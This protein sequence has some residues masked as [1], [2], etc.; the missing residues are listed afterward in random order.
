[1]CDAPQRANSQSVA[2]RD[3]TRFVNDVLEHPSI[4]AATGWIVGSLVAFVI[5]LTYKYAPGAAARAT[6]VEGTAPEGVIPVAAGYWAIA[7][8]AVLAILA[9]LEP[10]IGPPLA[11]WADDIRQR[12]VLRVP[13]IARLSRRD[14]GL[15]R[16]LRWRLWWAVPVVLNFL[17]AVLGLVLMVIWR[18]PSFVLSLFDWLL[19][20]PF[21]I[22]AG[23]TLRPW[24]LR[25]G[26]LF[27]VLL[28][29]AWLGWSLP[30]PQGLYGIAAGILAIFAVV[31]RW[32]WIER[33]REAFMTARG[34]D[35]EIERIGFAEDLRD[36]ALI[37]IVF[38]FLLIPLGLRQVDLAYDAFDLAR[39]E[40]MPAEELGQ[41]LK[42]L[43][44]FGA[45]LAKAVPLVD[46]S[47]VFHVANG[48]PITARTALGAQIVF[49][50]RASLDLLLI[51]AVVQAVQIAGRLNAQYS[52]FRVGKLPILDP[53]AERREFRKL[54]GQLSKHPHVPLI[55][56]PA[57][58]DFPEY[59][60]S[61]LVTVVCGDGQRQQIRAQIMRDTEARGACTVILAK[62]GWDHPE[63]L[64]DKEITAVLGY[65]VTNP[66]DD[67]V[68]RTAMRLLVENDP[69]GA[70]WPLADLVGDDAAPA[71]LRE[72]AARELGWL[73][74][75]SAG[76]VLLGCLSSAKT[77]REVRAQAGLALAKLG[78]EDAQR[79]DED[80]Q[81]HLESLAGS[82]SGYLSD[83][84]LI[85]VMSTAYA[86]ARSGG[87]VDKERL[88]A[89]FAEPLRPHALRAIR[90]ATEEL[91]KMK[92]VDADSFNMGENDLS[93]WE[94]PQHLVAVPAFELGIYTVT[95]EEYDAFCVATRPTEP[96]IT[97]PKEWEEWEKERPKW[98]VILVTWYDAHEYCDWLNSFTGEHFRL[99]SE[100][101]W[102]FACRAGSPTRYSWGDDFGFN[103]ANSYKS[104]LGRPSRVGSYDAN[105]WGFFDMHGNV[106][107]WC[108]DSWN[109]GYKQPRR[110]DDGS[111]WMT[112]DTQ[113]AVLRGGSWGGYPQFL[114]S[115]L[116][117]RVIRVNRYV[118][119]GFR[120]ARTLPR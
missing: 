74:A 7:V 62:Q 26:W 36:E 85:P 94:S 93:S 18:M 55:R 43:G 71:A 112:G 9:G 42:W 8:V 110:P 116:R 46:W 102:E 56:Q 77:P 100:A 49:A 119:V 30:P 24:W 53:F 101:E 95:F 87:A 75:S 45:E 50:M 21:A 31:R 118:Y 1:L 32:N 114:R 69:T 65:R 72:M 2:N 79:H 107:E 104:G 90:S 82:F 11:R 44:F 84:G 115:A 54:A 10:I 105:K 120:L 58:E 109:L 91:D 29:C 63:K 106:W 41:F 96:L 34:S 81:R 108:Q 19:A 103:R 35:P 88:A 76:D 12:L 52:A 20:R 33:D 25:Y 47:E 60:S 64:W 70:A 38:L 5:W 98:P 99:P 59:Q 23:A 66:D 89:L 57:I 28:G 22:F 92:R 14:L 27:S 67:I 6:Q 111:A 4:G 16:W 80:A 17:G 3:P 83:D 51:A 78:D 117:L 61:R 73:R 40:Q 48:S 39:G 37:A 15:W 113:L 13:D 68:R 86:L 97:L